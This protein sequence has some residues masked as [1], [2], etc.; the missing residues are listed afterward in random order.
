MIQTMKVQK[1]RWNVAFKIN[2]DFQDDSDDN[3]INS[4]E[5]IEETKPKKKVI[6]RTI[7]INKI[8]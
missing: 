6:N 5:E 8:V 7:N 1:L 2:R 3:E 4:D